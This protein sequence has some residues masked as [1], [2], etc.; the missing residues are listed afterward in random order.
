MI[1]KDFHASRRA[2]YAS[3]LKDDSVGFVFAGREREW[4]G[5]EMY[6]FIPYAN[7]YYLT[8]FTYPEAVLMVVKRNGYVRETL[9]ID[10]PDEKA[11]LDRSFLHKGKRKGTNRYWKCRLFGTF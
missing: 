9:F 8:G 1:S 5:D 6:P 10:H 7:F 3:V 4:K 11:A 2:L